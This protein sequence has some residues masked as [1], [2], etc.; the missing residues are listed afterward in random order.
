MLPAFQ[1]EI[2]AHCVEQTHAVARLFPE[3]EGA[4]ILD[5]V[6]NLTRE[7]GGQ[8]DAKEKL[9]MNLG[10]WWRPALTV[11][12]IEGLPSDLNKAGNVVHKE[13]KYRLSVR[14]APNC[15]TDALAE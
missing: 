4:A 9:E 13:L 8:A 10:Q 14:T 5:D 2:P 7:F 1:P 12:G 11:I 6:G 15:D 3:R